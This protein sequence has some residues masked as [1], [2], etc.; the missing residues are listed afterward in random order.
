[1]GTETAYPI[2][3]Y[4]PEKALEDAKNIIEPDYISDDYEETE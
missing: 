3:L 1:M 4:V 2:E